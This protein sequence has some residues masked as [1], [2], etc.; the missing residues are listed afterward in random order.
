MSTARRLTLPQLRADIDRGRDRLIE[1]LDRLPG[2]LEQQQQAVIDGIRGADAAVTWLRAQEATRATVA[3]PKRQRAQ[4]PAVAPKRPR[5]PVGSQRDPFSERVER[6][7]QA[8]AELYESERRVASKTIETLTTV[9]GHFCEMVN[10]VRELK[11]QLAQRDQEL[12]EL[13][14]RSE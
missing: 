11:A 5:V 9:T 3:A 10:R 14:R 4:R 12:E 6:E 13:R 1:V 2:H 8:Y 7:A